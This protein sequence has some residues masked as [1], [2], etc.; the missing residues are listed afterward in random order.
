MRFIFRTSTFKHFLL[1]LL[2]VCSAG[3]IAD[4][5]PLSETAR[6]GSDLLVQSIR[7]FV[8][9]ETQGLGHT[10]AIEIPPLDSKTRVG[11]CTAPQVFLPP[12]GRLW[13][14]GHV[15]VRC[16]SPSPWLIYVPVLVKVTG[17]YLI[18][19]KKISAGQILSD[20]DF[21]VEQGDLTQLPDGVLTL[22]DQALGQRARTGLAPQLPL[23]RDLLVRIPTIRQGQPVKIVIQGEG[24]SVS[25]NGLALTNGYE[26]EIIRVKN[27]AGRTMQGRVRA[28]GIVEVTQ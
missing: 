7:H 3:S 18:S 27:D 10:I 9:R 1:G 28:S 15:G 25:S 26:G 19:A 21:T 13:G 14:K 20:T 12:G 16:M 4:Q 5:S 8:T 23:R 24:F 2:T 17:T 22:P 11:P 6:P